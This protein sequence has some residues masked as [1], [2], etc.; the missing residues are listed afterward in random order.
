MKKLLI[1]FIA[2]YSLSACSVFS[3]VK[4]ETQ[5]TYLINTVPNP[6]VKKSQRRISLLVTQPEASSLYN[7]TSMAYTTHPYQIGY[8]VKSTWAEPPPQMLQPLVIQTLQRTHYFRSVGSLSNIGQ[9]NLTLNTQLIQLEQ[10]YSRQPHRVHVIL[11]AQIVNPNT[12]QI[13][14]SK[15][16]SAHEI[17]RRDTTYDGVVATNQA[18]AKILNQLAAFCLRAI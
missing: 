16:F 18:V 4:T 15:E 6:A 13:L 1:L 8:F 7:T 10:D 9:Y 3:P 2:L 17:I 5:T 12:N 14:A 11:R